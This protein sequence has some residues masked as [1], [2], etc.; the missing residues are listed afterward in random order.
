LKL[1]RNVPAHKPARAGGIRPDAAGIDAPRGIHFAPRISVIRDPKHSDS[2]RR[3]RLGARAC[4]V[5]G[6]GILLVAW[7]DAD[8]R[9]RFGLIAVGAVL[10]VVVIPL[11][12]HRCNR[13][14][15]CRRSFSETPADPDEQVSRLPLFNSVERCP[16]CGLDL[17]SAGY[18]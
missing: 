5:A 1:L 9:T 2:F 18:L 14:P 4:F 13:C 12:F 6:V 17:D 7:G 3:W 8:P 16:F 15:R 10:I 11:Y